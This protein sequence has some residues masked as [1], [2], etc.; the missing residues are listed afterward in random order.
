MQN[1]VRQVKQQFLQEQLPLL[2][3][4]NQE[5]NLND[6]NVRKQQEQFPKDFSMH[7]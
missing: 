2:S 6:K 1:L 5:A 7:A 3:C 4:Q